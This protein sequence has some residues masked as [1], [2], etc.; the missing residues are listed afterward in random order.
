MLWGAF[1]AASLCQQGGEPAPRFEIEFYRRGAPAKV[2]LRGFPVDVSIRCVDA[3][4]NTNP[5]TQRVGL[6]GIEGI[7]PEEGVALERGRVL[8]KGVIL[9]G[10][11][12]TVG[13]TQSRRIRLLPGFLSLLP[14]LLAIVLLFVIRHSVFAFLA[15]IWGG[16][17]FLEGLFPSFLRTFDTAV[18]G[19][20]IQPEHASILLFVLCIGGLTAVLQKS[21]GSHALADAIW[22]VIES[23]R[24]VQAVAG[25]L[26]ALFFF[27]PRA[28]S[29]WAGTVVRPLTDRLRISRAKLAFIL[30]TTASPVSMLVILSTF[31]AL[32]IDALGGAG[33][34]EMTPLGIFV[35]TLPFSFYAFFALAIAGSVIVLQ[36]D[37]GPM[38]R[39]EQSALATGKLSWL[40]AQPLLD[41]D[42]TL[43]A[44]A[45]GRPHYW[46]NGVVPLAA[47]LVFL[48]AGMLSEGFHAA[49]PD[50]GLRDALLAAAQG[51]GF[52]RALIWSGFGASL[53][54]I[55][56]STATRSLALAEG[57]ETWVRGVRGAARGGILLILAWALV[58]VCDGLDTGA[59]LGSIAGGWIPRSMTPAALFVIAGLVS[60]A[61]GSAITTT[62]VMLASGLAL[63]GSESAVVADETLRSASVAAILSGSLLGDHLSPYAPTTI[64]S[65]AGAGCGLTEHFHTQLPYGLCAA[66]A[67]LV[68]GFIPAGLGIPP[69]FSIVVGAVALFG[70]VFLAGHMQT[71]PLHAAGTTSFVSEEKSDQFPAAPL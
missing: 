9:K 57:V 23:R 31:A 58:G 67:A 17:I 69:V 53:V 12:I 40:R 26:G 20:I 14:P 47:L 24:L 7:L 33:L 64:L 30:D 41:A 35:K 25:F 66:V 54:A 6:F 8:L 11:Y 61:T 50:A 4:G 5:I 3:E 43:M 18:L 34:G 60:F 51:E 52:G 21:G 46:F 2:S 71:V 39:S 63:G 49:S 10:D 19:S 48:A 15:G 56:L 59:Y 36:R 68:F 65:A 29:L 38:R 42:V 62:V 16:M 45:E 44:P 28:G 27:E 37:F 13:D 22:R 1:I 55:G 32:Q 70:V